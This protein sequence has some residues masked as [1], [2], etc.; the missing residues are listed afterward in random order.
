MTFRFTPNQV[1]L[2]FLSQLPRH[3][4]QLIDTIVAEES[5]RAHP[6]QTAID[7]KDW[8][9]KWRFYAEELEGIRH[10]TMALELN[11][12]CANP[13]NRIV[14]IAAGRHDSSLLKPAFHM[15]M[16]VRL[17]YIWTSSSAGWLLDV[18]ALKQRAID[19]GAGELCH[20][21]EEREAAVVEYAKALAM[22]RVE[23]GKGFG[24]DDQILRSDF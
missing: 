15:P 11:E 9:E 8:S 2:T 23:E 7:R 3:H 12:P 18:D 17:K 10:F 19:E 4:V 1:L 24:R 22:K 20:N 6:T 13:N 14:D 21:A 5:L 16:S